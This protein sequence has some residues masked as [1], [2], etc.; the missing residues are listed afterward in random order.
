VRN[1]KKD[2]IDIINKKFPD[3][4]AII[5]EVQDYLETGNISNGSNNVSLR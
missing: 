4:R 2:L 3:F 5:V 1:T